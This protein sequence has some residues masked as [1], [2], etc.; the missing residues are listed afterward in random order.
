MKRDVEIL[1]A[2]DDDGH[3]SLVEKNLRRAGICNPISRLADG[4][5]AIDFFFPEDPALA[6]KRRRP[7]LLLLDIRMPHVDGVEVLR[8]LREDPLWSKMPVIMLTTTDDPREIGR[9]SELGCNVYI[10]KPV[11]YEAFVEAV[12][13]VGLFLSIVEVPQ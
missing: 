3:Y 11:E 7:Y 1:I 12:R 6:K 5:E 10:V 9:C 13:N 2:E 4:R 8:R